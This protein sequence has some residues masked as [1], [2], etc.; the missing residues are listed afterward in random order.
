M[1][2][3]T[4]DHKTQRRC[5]MIS[6]WTNH[7]CSA[8]WSSAEQWEQQWEFHYANGPMSNEA[9][10]HFAI[11]W[12]GD[13]SVFALSDLDSEPPPHASRAHKLSVFWQQS[14]NT[15]IIDLG[16]LLVEGRWHSCRYGDAPER[17]AYLPPFDG[18]PLMTFP[19]KRERF[20]SLQLLLGGQA[21]GCWNPPIDNFDCSRRYINKDEL[22][23]TFLP[24]VLALSSEAN[25]GSCFC[26]QRRAEKCLTHTA[27]KKVSL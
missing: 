5:M 1:F 2:Y 4:D 8:L 15:S 20:P 19:V 24:G 9:V 13:E 25:D 18:V 6:I 26:T 16:A 17:C 3:E 23:W 22:N 7:D 14:K 10:F 11:G 21:P 27:P 12:W